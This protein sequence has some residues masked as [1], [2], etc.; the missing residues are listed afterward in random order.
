MYA[1]SP[2]E[3]NLVSPKAVDFRAGCASGKPDCEVSFA[4]VKA[5]PLKDGRLF[6]WNRHVAELEVVFDRHAL[7]GHG[8]VYSKHSKGEYLMERTLSFMYF[9]VVARVGVEQMAAFHPLSAAARINT[10]VA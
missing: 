7:L 3:E 10:F 2:W 8:V 4:I 1:R 5:S 6:L 9:V